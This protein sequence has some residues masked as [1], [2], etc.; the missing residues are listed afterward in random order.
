M[1]STQPL[2]KQLLGKRGEDLAVSYLQNHGFR[3]IERN[4]KARYGEIDIVSLK[5]GVLVFIE[6]K[7]R[8]GTAFGTPEEAVT[9]KKLRDVVRTAEYYKIGH[10]GLPDAMR[11]DVIGIQLDDHEQIISFNHIENVT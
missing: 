6:V 11:I 1:K 9:P 3:I 4:F 5:D 7:T 10:R 2:H 8:I